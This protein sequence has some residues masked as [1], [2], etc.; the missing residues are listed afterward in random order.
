MFRGLDSRPEMATL[1]ERIRDLIEGDPDLSI[2]GVARAAGMAGSQLHKILNGTTNNPGVRTLDRIARGIGVQVSKLLS[3]VDDFVF[4]ESVDR[5]ARFMLITDGAVS[6]EAGVSG[7][8]EQAPSGGPSTREP[9]A[10]VTD[11]K[12]HS[13]NTDRNRDPA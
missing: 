13:R 7:E 3:G 2:D 10:P 1:G 4:E 12:P 9:P 6:A 8:S 5:V 11:R